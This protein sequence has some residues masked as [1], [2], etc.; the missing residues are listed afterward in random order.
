[1][2]TKNALCGCPSRLLIPIN[3]KAKDVITKYEKPKAE[4]NVFA[5]KCLQMPLLLHL[6]CVFIYDFL[7]FVF[8]TA[9]TWKH[10]TGDNLD[11]CPQHSH[12]Y[13]APEKTISLPLQGESCAFILTCICHGTESIRD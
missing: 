8:E 10:G 13:L 4:A 2:T 11:L 1:M 12:S 5:G 7:D 6:K 9:S 3:P